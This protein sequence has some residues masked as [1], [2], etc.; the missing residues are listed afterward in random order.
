MNMTNSSPPYR[1]EM[2]YSTRRNLAL[3][4]VLSQIS[5]IDAFSVPTIPTIATTRSGLG[6]GGPSLASSS[7]HQKTPTEKNSFF[8]NGPKFQ[9]PSFALHVA[10]EPN[11]GMPAPTLPFTTDPYQILAISGQ[12][13]KS[14]IKRA[15]RQAAL[16]YHPDVRTTSQSSKE[17][18]EQANDDF[19]RINAA[20]AFLT[21][22]ST[23]KPTAGM[24][25]PAAAKTPNSARRYGRSYASTTKNSTNSYKGQSY[26]GSSNTYGSGNNHGQKAAGASGDFWSRN[27]YGRAPGGTTGGAGAGVGAAYKRTVTPPRAANT[28]R[29]RSNF[30][31]AAYGGTNVQGTA[32]KK[33]STASSRTAASSTRTTTS[34]HTTSARTASSGTAAGRKDAPRTYTTAQTGTIPTGTGSTGAGGSYWSRHG[35][36]NTSSAPAKRATRATSP[37]SKPAAA[38]PTASRSKANGAAYGA[39]YGYSNPAPQT[40]KKSGDLFDASKFHSQ[41]NTGNAGTKKTTGVSS[42]TASTSYSSTSPGAYAKTSS[43]SS[44]V[45]SS[46]VGS[47]TSTRTQN[48]S[49]PSTSYSS[50]SPGAYNNAGTRSATNTQK[51]SPPSSSTTPSTTPGA[52]S[53]VGTRS[54]TTTQN[55]SSQSPST[56]YSST[57]AYSKTTHQKTH[58]YGHSARR[59]STTKATPT[60]KPTSNTARYAQPKRRT[61]PQQPKKKTNAVNRRKSGD[62]FD[63]DSFHARFNP[64]HAGAAYPDTTSTS[65]PQTTES[66]STTSTTTGA[67]SQSYAPSS[68][69]TSNVKTQGAQT[70]TANSSNGYSYSTAQKTNSSST[71]AKSAPSTVN[72]TGING[73]FFDSSRFHSQWNSSKKATKKSLEEKEEAER[74]ERLRLEAELAA[75]FAAQ[76]AEEVAQ[77]RAEV[78]KRQREH[79]ERL[80]V[81]AEAESSA[82]MEAE[83][84]A[85][86]QEG[87]GGFFK[88]VTNLFSN[89]SSKASSSTESSP[90]P[91]KTL[92][93]PSPPQGQQYSPYEACSII[94][95]HEINPSMDKPKA[96]KLMLDNHYVPVKRSQ[97]YVVYKKYMDGDMTKECRWG[98]YL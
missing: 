23:D 72:A 46:T 7:H 4:L 69:G 95:K 77:K 64:T 74:I 51:T 84:A 25:A 62:F 58:I 66:A 54:S 98:E 32:P 38:A 60:P 20:Y 97:L 70:S 57:G 11:I 52:Y 3:L 94:A 45:Y 28:Q 37:A 96:M 13:T 34:A 9:R 76:K 21:G 59:A 5:A 40:Q 53:N 8:Q 82:R 30:Y 36:S 10:A 61:Q 73:D 17:E 47:R 89:S 12:V 75:N 18:R 92:S 42:K 55:P 88:T 71:T 68:T 90:R 35:T 15:Y 85:R 50:T 81:A 1:S 33:T 31:S 44:G 2:K 24:N 87:F 65:T 63:A 29:P 14:E 86:S 19:A 6:V 22:K 26:G 49:S 16:M 91:G 67:T 93:V 43:P 41:W 79:S 80:R 39:A 56:S 48:T 78:E 27:G 83:E